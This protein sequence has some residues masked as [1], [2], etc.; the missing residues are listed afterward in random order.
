M[1]SGLES[2]DWKLLWTK[3]LHSP[4]GSMSS[5]IMSLNSI[6]QNHSETMDSIFSQEF[7]ELYHFNCMDR[8]LIFSQ[9]NESSTILFLD[10]GTLI[11]PQDINWGD[12]KLNIDSS[13]KYIHSLSL[14][15]DLPYKR[16][17][18]VDGKPQENVSLSLNSFYFINGKK[19]PRDL[20]TK[21]KNGNVIISNVSG[22]VLVFDHHD[23]LYTSYVAVE[24]KSE[25]VYIVSYDENTR[26]SKKLWT[27]IHGSDF[28]VKS[29]GS[30]D[31][32]SRM[33]FYDIVTTSGY[34]VKL[35]SIKGSDSLTTMTTN[36]P[37][38]E[39]NLLVFVDGCYTTNYRYRSDGSLFFDSPSKESIEVYVLVPNSMNCIDSCRVDN[40]NR[41]TF[42]NIRVNTIGYNSSINSLTKTNML[43]TR[44]DIM[45]LRR[46]LE[47]THTLEQTLSHLSKYSINVSNPEANVMMHYTM[48]RMLYDGTFNYSDSS[49]LNDPSDDVVI[50]E[51]TNDEYTVE[52]NISWQEDSSV[53]IYY[54]ESKL[55]KY[56]TMVFDNN[57]LLIH[58]ND[59]E[60]ALLQFNMPQ[61]TKNL[62]FVC[63]NP[64]KPAIYGELIETTLKRIPV[65]NVD[66]ETYIAMSNLTNDLVND[67]GLDD[68][69]VV[70]QFT[71][72]TKEFE[73][74]DLNND[75]YQVIFRTPYFTFFPPEDEF[76]ENN[77]MVFVNGKKAFLKYEY[78][79]NGNRVQSINNREVVVSDGGYYY[80]LNGIDNFKIPRNRFKELG[81][82]IETENIMNSKQNFDAL[83]NVKGEDN[84]YILGEDEAVLDLVDGF[85]EHTKVLFND[86]SAKECIVFQFNDDDLDD[87]IQE[88]NPLGRVFN[89]PNRTYEKKNLLVFVDGY[90]T[91]DY[92]IRGD[93]LVL[94]VIP[95]TVEIYVFK[96]YDYL[97]LDDNKYN[98]NSYNFITKNI[99]RSIF[100]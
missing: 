8:D 91:T 99:K 43:L 86:T 95:K 41:F 85:D 49:Y 89:L 55:N 96:Q 64:K 32:L 87:L 34:S 40:E 42:S 80:L 37:I 4:V 47:R 72:N 84:I 51:G 33:R 67:L 44:S 82:F 38:R 75:L 6:A 29:N 22:E 74:I 15:P 20:I 19:I 39:D 59:I 11:D 7:D 28:I 69:P 65:E 83:G 70:H 68:K 3:I 14:N 77:V 30:V 79:L 1:K 2:Y 60:W 21:D 56:S 36:Y 93:Q 63:L 9:K 31:R 88:M 52:T 5:Y 13:S 12:K 81:L 57:G 78:D 10:D 58:P 92:E 27:E 48:D 45:F 100:F 66:I 26:A 46:F 61:V 17:Q 24:G 50:N 76:I 53:P 23:N 71:Y 54:S 25:V 73:D 18:V 97:Y 16:I 35:K 62:T 90:R 98:S 94:S